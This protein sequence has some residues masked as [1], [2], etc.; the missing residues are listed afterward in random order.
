MLRLLDHSLLEEIGRIFD[1]IIRPSVSVTSSSWRYTRPWHNLSFLTSDRRW[2]RKYVR[3]KKFLHRSRQNTCFHLPYISSGTA[4]RSSLQ[5]LSSQAA[6]QRNTKKIWALRAEFG[7][8]VSA[9]T[10]EDL[11][12]HVNLPRMCAVYRQH[13]GLAETRREK[14]RPAPKHDPNK[15][16]EL[17]LNALPEHNKQKLDKQ[18]PLYQTDTSAQSHSLAQPSPLASHL[19]HRSATRGSFCHLRV[20][21]TSLILGMML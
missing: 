4:K 8:S 5:G 11:R 16:V 17:P 19:F 21:L 20:R 6:W 10:Y 1:D 13:Q 2:G 9:K 18:T 14:V 12:Y 7:R 3:K 15:G